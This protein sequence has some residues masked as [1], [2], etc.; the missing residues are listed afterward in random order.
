MNRRKKKGRN[1]TRGKRANTSL[2]N[3]VPPSL[4]TKHGAV[5]GLTNPFSSQARG[6]RIPD[7]DSAFSTTFQLRTLVNLTTIGNQAAIA[8]NPNPSGIFKQATAHVGNTVTTWGALQPPADIAAF[9]ANFS[10][11]RIVSYGV[12]F[13]STVAPL[14]MSGEYRAV[15]MQALATDGIVIDGNMWNSVVNDTASGLDLHYIAKPSGVDWKEYT[16]LGND[17]DYDTLAVLF[18][19]LPPA[20]TYPSS[21]SCEIVMNLEVL[22]VTASAMSVMA[23]PGST[24]DPLVLQAAS[25]VHAKH[26]GIQ[27]SGSSFFQRLGG[28]AK[29]ALLDIA[30]SAVPFAG[31]AA[32]RIFGGSPSYPMIVD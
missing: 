10:R 20:G 4:E 6:A 28:F 27:K 2:S 26:K 29:D 31:G 7:D 19:G 30:A 15:V 18:N 24:H 14:N 32:R 22:T 9:N 23:K 17:A 1:L 21:I 25:R 8:I 13:Y 12:R 11:Y 3:R 16:A 5:T